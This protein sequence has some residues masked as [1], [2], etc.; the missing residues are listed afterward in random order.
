MLGSDFSPSLCQ[1]P[2][3]ARSSIKQIN[4]FKDHSQPI[5]YVRVRKPHVALTG[6]IDKRV[7]GSPKRKCP[8]RLSILL[9]EKQLGPER[10]TTV[11]C[12]LMRG[13]GIYGEQ[14]SK[15]EC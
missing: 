13:S 6:R 12:I 4:I 9:D 11:F 15:A 3:P 8:S 14:L 1:R 10:K 5:P 2:D 7:W